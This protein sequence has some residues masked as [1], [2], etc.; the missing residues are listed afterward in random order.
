MRTS[1]EFSLSA[2]PSTLRTYEG[3]TE[4]EGEQVRMFEQTAGAIINYQATPALT[5]SASS[6]IALHPFMRTGSTDPAYRTPSFG[7]NLR[8]WAEARYVRS[9]L[10]I[11]TLVEPVLRVAGWGDYGYEAEGLTNPARAY[12]KYD[13]EVSRHLYVGKLARGGV[14][15]AYYG[16]ANLDRF[17]R[18]Q[19]SFLSK[20]RIVGI[21]A[22]VDTFDAIGLAGAYYGFNVLDLFKL[23]A[24]YN[25]AWARNLDESTR[26]Q[27]FDGID[28]DLGT[29]GPWGTYVQG[30]FGYTL[31]GNL[32]RYGSRWGA[33]VLIFKPLGR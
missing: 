5:L 2:L 25:H 24:S 31:R 22:G 16:G 21:P 33:Q 15:A 18:Y 27:Q 9:S 23:E 11:V 32:D 4:R 29:A 12:V 8:A 7:L 14:S 28:F 19:S 3:D 13:V 17:S 26:F 10:E 1:I 30:A 6:H 20:P